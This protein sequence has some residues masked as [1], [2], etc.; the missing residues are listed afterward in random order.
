MI[1]NGQNFNQSDDIVC[2][3]GTKIRPC[4]M[5]EHYTHRGSAFDRISIYKYLQFVSIVKR[6]QQQRGDYKF[7]D[8]HRQKEEFV[9]KPLKRIKQLA[10]VV[11]RGKLFENEESEDAIPGGHPETDACHTNLSLILLSLFVPWNHLSSLFLVEGATLETYKKFCWRVWGKCKP[12][13]PSHIRFYA[14]NVCQIRKT[15]IEVRADIAARIDAREAARLAVDDWRDKTID[16]ANSNGEA[17]ID[18]TNVGLV[19]FGV[20]T[21]TSLADSVRKTRHKWAIDDFTK[22]SDNNL[23]ISLI[24]NIGAESATHMEQS[25]TIHRCQVDELDQP[26]IGDIDH[27]SEDVVSS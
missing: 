21:I 10:L 14:N 3:D 8:G 5:Y 16:M 25:L 2:V 27:V 22:Y 1:L 26:D 4:S 11:L 13:L 15:R 24:M 6:S 17:E 9:Q 19:E 12:K 7:A 23:I 18:P 20:Q